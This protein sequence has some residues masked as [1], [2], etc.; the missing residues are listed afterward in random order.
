MLFDSDNEL[1]SKISDILTKSQFNL[2]GVNL[3]KGFV[4]KGRISY[5]EYQNKLYI[6]ETDEKKEKHYLWD[7]SYQITGILKD[8]KY[9]K[10][11]VIF[12]DEEDQK[13]KVSGMIEFVEG[14]ENQLLAVKSER[15]L[16]GKLKSVSSF[17][18]SFIICIN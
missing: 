15:H 1:C 9:S 12:L 8:I 13:I 16:F 2:N 6:M 10:S 7:F 11:E 4:N 3:S 5:S 17:Y 18:S 14:G